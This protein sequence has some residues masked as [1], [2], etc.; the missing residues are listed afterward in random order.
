MSEHH[1]R[2]SLDVSLRLGAPPSSRA[3]SPSGQPRRA[4]VAAVDAEPV[5]A[6]APLSCG[7]REVVEDYYRLEPWVTPAAPW[8]SRW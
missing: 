3:D 4:V 7:A 2:A 6:P 5:T 1:G 8:I